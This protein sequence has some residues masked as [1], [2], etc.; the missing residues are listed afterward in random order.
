MRR[1]DKTS[2]R[3]NIV[4]LKARRRAAELQK[5]VLKGARPTRASAVSSPLAAWLILLAASLVW[6]LVRSLLAGGG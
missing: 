6:A 4:D 2:D 5:Q 3:E 1:P